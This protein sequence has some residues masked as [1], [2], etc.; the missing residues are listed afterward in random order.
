MTLSNAYTP[1]TIELV[2]GS[3][4]TV[5]IRALEPAPSTAFKDLTGATVIFRAVGNGETIEKTITSFATHEAVACAVDVVFS[6]S[7]TRKIN[8]PMTWEAEYRLSGQEIV[9]AG[10]KLTGTGGANSD[11]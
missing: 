7:D 11:A 6:A 8:L 5:R 9:F 10:G 4:V 1:Q 3:T 2:R